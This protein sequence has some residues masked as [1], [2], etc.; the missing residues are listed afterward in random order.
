MDEAPK[1]IA[2]Q[3]IEK[4][5]KK[6][7][8]LCQFLLLSELNLHCLVIDID[9]YMTVNLSFLQYTTSSIYFFQDYNTNTIPLEF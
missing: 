1:N 2:L 6:R 3:K 4:E 7:P 9:T 5:K 8:G